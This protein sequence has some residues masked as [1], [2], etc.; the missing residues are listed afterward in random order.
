MSEHF[1]HGQL[2]GEILGGN[3]CLLNCTPELVDLDEGEDGGEVHEGGVKLEVL[4]GGADM[5]AGGEHAL[6]D[7]ANAH[8]VEDPEVLQGVM[9]NSIDYQQMFLYSSVRHP[10]VPTTLLELPKKVC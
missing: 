4:V 2:L 3:K 1:K 6:E 7:D 8:R 10:V 5:V 9:V